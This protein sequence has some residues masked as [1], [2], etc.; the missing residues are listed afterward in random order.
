M[1]AMAMRSIPIRSIP[2]QR[3]QIA[4]R[5]LG[6]LALVLLQPWRWLRSSMRGAGGS[7]PRRVLLI[8]FWGIGSLQLLTPAVQALRV[9]HPKA[10]L[11][12]LT[13]AENADFATG[14]GIFDEVLR[15]DAGCSSWI[16]I[17]R[18][19]LRLVSELRDRSYGVV[20][21]FEFFTRFSAVVSFL[22]GASR[23]VGFSTASVWRGGLHT[24]GVTF[25]RY[26]HVARNFRALA[27]GENGR[28]L[29]SEEITA[30]QPDAQDRAVVAEH[31][32][33]SGAVI[34]L[35]INAG[36]LSLE[37]RWP[38]DNFVG[39]AQR[40]LGET[41]ASLV[42]VGAASEAAYVAE[43][44][45]ALGDEDPR[46]LNLAGKLSIGQLVALLDNAAL[47][48]TNDSGP[49]H[50]AATL[51]TPTVGLF[52]PE[53]PQMYAPLG[54]RATAL[55]RPTICSP[56]INVHENKV[57]TCIHGR[58]ECLV[59]LSVDEVLERSLTEFRG[60]SALLMF[61]GSENLRH[62]A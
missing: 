30:Y 3:L 7:Q 42:F 51:G 36:R 28:E 18:R 16:Q 20:Y 52:G 13:L 5:H 1:R 46:V 9:A 38:M 24:A 41:E 48:V 62:D 17:F 15:L 14:L 39:L 31:L 27:G 47:V 40:L 61:P 12:L 10:R 58:P 53:T 22:T 35:N 4:D 19:I 49:M 44:V 8:K 60:R 23:S 25:N 59:N 56:C 29:S 57:A 50:L 43:A 26:W 11:E 33:E 32:G 45:K 54:A 2:I 6:R 21:D 37:R 55:Y 34:V